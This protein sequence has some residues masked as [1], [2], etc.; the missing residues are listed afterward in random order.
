MTSALGQAG[1]VVSLRLVEPDG[2]N[3]IVTIP[4]AA[5]RVLTQAVGAIARGESVSLESWP[6]DL[7]IRDAAALLDIPASEVA[8]RLDGGSLASHRDD[9]KRRVAMADVLAYR[10]Q[11]RQ[12]RRAA[13]DELSRLDQELGLT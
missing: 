6:A 2:G 8:E 12:D 10:A 9:D 5:F 1:D 11:H 7:S 4:R 3:Q 13:L